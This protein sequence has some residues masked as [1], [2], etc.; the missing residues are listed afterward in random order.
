MILYIC[1]H[2][3][4]ESLSTSQASSDGERP[5]S[6]RGRQ[7]YASVVEKLIERDFAPDLIATSPLLRCRQTGDLIAQGVPGQPETMQLDALAPG[8][9]LDELIQWTGQQA[10]GQM[11]WVGHMPDVA[12][13]TVA[14]A[15]DDS[16]S[17]LFPQGS[18][19]AL[20]FETSPRLGE[21][22]LLWL[23]SAEDLRC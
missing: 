3:W 19:A 9:Y 12:G 22:E 16:G 20:R 23:L 21:G 11:A 4:A 10:Y 7:R 17:I 14:L 2:A 15:R 8:A 13:M 5:L 1:R 6:S 18:V